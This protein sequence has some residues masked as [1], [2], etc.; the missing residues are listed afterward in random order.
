MNAENHQEGLHRR[1]D[2]LTDAENAPFNDGNGSKPDKD[3]QCE[4]HQRSGH[5]SKGTYDPDA[6]AWIDE[7]G[8]K[9]PGHQVEKWRA[10]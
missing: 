8:A 4:F 5:V 10:V 2:E 6:Q 7:N 9:I 3:V 1:P